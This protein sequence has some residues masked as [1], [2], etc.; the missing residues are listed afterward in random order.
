MDLVIRERA[1]V[2]AKRL[3][4]QAAAEISAIGKRYSDMKAVR[5]LAPGYEFD[6]LRDRRTELLHAV[7]RDPAAIAEVEAAML[8]LKRT[9]PKIDMT[10]LEEARLAEVRACDLVLRDALAD[11]RARAHAGTLTEDDTK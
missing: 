7:P 10:D 3:R 8:A 9:P 6:A 4:A 11:L 2:I 1:G 5:M